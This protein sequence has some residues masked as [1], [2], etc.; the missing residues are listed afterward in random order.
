ME[1]LL[2]LGSLVLFFSFV[3]V[4]THVLRELVRRE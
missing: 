4:L 1:D 3:L 2:L